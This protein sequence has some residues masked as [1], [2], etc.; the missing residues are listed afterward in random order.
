MW[1]ELFSILGRVFV[2]QRK[3]AGPIRIA[4]LIDNIESPTA[5]T[6]RQLLLLLEG[7][8]R[9]EFEPY[10]YVLQNS[11]WLQKHFSLCPVHVLD[12]LSM[13]KISSWRN[14]L[15]FV[16]ELR[17]Q[18]VDILQAQFTDDSKLGMISGFLARVPGIVATRKNQGYWMTRGSLVLQKILN[19]I[20]DVIVANSEA[21]KQWAY[22]IEG[23]ALDRVQVI[24]NGFAGELIPVSDERRAAA[25][26][27]LGL[28]SDTPVAGIVANLRPVKRIDVF[29]RAAAIAAATLHA[30]QFVVV[31]EGVERGRLEELCTELGLADRVIFWAGAPM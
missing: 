4:F 21:T 26:E 17:R 8:S 16:R 20:P 22:R 29:L 3:A 6:E 31:G 15:R 13:K 10:L 27:S 25:R 30:A 23:I 12:I 11:I 1:E 9:E 5:G 18:K 14:T 24:H 19:H 28:P 7:L 2:R